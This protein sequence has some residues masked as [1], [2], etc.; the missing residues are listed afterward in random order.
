MKLKKKED[1]SVD[2]SVLLEEGS[3]YPLEEIQRQSLEQ[4]LK[5]RSSSDCPTWASNPQTVTKPRH[6]CGYQVLTD[7]NLIQAVS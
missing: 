7:R 6:Y 4:K 1:H 5:A 2:T 3:K